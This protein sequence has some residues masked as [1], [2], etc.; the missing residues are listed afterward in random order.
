MQLIGTSFQ[1]Y[2]CAHAGRAMSGG[3]A[4]HAENGVDAMCIEPSTA[5]CCFEGA[6]LEPFANPSG[7]IMT[8]FTTAAQMSS[9]AERHSGAVASAPAHASLLKRSTAGR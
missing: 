6:A 4:W 8:A 7:W 2:I 5:Q 9:T 1:M 3:A